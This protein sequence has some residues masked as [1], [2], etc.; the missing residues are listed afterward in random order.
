[1][2]STSRYAYL[3]TSAFVK[4]CWPEPESAAL[5]SYL[6]AWPLRVSSSLLWTEALRAAQRQPVP[7][8][9]RVHN[10]LRRIAM[11]ELDRAILRQAGT[12]APPD[13]RSLDAI[14]LAAASSLGSDLGVLLTYDQRMSAAARAQGFVIAAPSP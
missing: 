14:H 8:V 13:I 7:R 4:L 12:L 5:D 9:E 1:M 3:D 2:A 6:R 10:A 11:I